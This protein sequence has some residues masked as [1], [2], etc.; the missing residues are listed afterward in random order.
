MSRDFSMLQKPICSF[1][2]LVE[3]ISEQLL[4]PEFA[5][6]LNRDITDCHVSVIN[7]AGRYFDYFL[8]LFDV[9]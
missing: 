5:K 9:F 8:K 3:G 2:L 1:N 6:I 7:I 4:V